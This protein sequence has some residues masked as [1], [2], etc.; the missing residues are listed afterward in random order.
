MP[1]HAYALHAFANY[2]TCSG[3]SQRLA[4]V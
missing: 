3:P 2:P 4:G 1:G